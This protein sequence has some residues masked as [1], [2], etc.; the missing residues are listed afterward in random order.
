[1]IRGL[2]NQALD[3]HRSLRNHYPKLGQ[4]TAQRV[5]DLRALAHQEIA[6]PK[7]DC[8]SLRCFALDLHE[9]HRRPL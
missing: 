5:D 7:D 4:M 9:S 6:S 3:V 2:S 1:L 8:R